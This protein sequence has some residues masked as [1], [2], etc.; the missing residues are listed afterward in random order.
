MAMSWN[1]GFR[2]GLRSKGLGWGNALEALTL[3]DSF[4]WDGSKSF[5]WDRSN[6]LKRELRI[7]S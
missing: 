4:A 5:A 1:S 3:V 6:A 7:D 2:R